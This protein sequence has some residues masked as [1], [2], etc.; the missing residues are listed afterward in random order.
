MK[1]VLVTGSTGYI[2]SAVASNLVQHSGYDLVVPVRTVSE[3]G[4]RSCYQVLINDIGDVPPSVFTQVDVVVHLAGKAHDLSGS[5]DFIHEIRRINL[6]ATLDLARLALSARVKKF[7]Y[8]SSV[9]VC[10]DATEHSAFTEDSIP[11]PSTYYA[12]AKRDAENGLWDIVNDSSMELVIIRPPLVYSGSAPGNFG[13][14]L[15]LVSL[16]LP[17]PFRHTDN[18]RSIIALDN[19]VDFIRLCIDHPSS[20]GNLFLISDGE[21]VSTED[22]VR[23]LA[24]GM[25]RRLVLFP[26][27]QK[28]LRSLAVSLGKRRLYT[29]L[30]RSLVIDSAKA[31]NTLSWDPPMTAK[32]GLVK[33]GRDYS[34]SQMD[35]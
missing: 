14:L 25:E 32:D 35:L 21:D 33:A 10:G 6:D 12:K 26:F 9:G 19:L 11:H 23:N 24:Q 29:Q 1:K 17:L 31:R 13:R 28:V 3:S 16:G 18:S 34:Q 30:F 20:G 4:N 22:I 8:L 15:R 7:V 5:Q 27:P 2:G